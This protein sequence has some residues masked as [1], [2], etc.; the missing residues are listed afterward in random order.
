MA[1]RF[2]VFKFIDIH[3]FFMILGVI[4]QFWGFY[5][6]YPPVAFITTG[7]IFLYLAI[8]GASE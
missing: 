4:L 6:I 1:N 7:F 3:D 2:N 8:K 5:A